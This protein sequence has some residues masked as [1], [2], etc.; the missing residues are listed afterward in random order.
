MTDAV[1]DLIVLA[2]LFGVL[3]RDTICGGTVTVAQCVALQTLTRG[4]WDNAALAGAL[5]VTAGAATRLVDGLEKK[6][7]CSRSR[8][9]E[10]RRRL[11]IE[12]TPEG[13]AEAKRLRDA[14]A[15]AVG[16]ILGAVPRGK[17]TQ[18]RESLHLLRVAAE[19]TRDRITCC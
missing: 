1:E 15:D 16:L 3:E 6:G 4:E 17:R 14:T 13:R 7:W 19:A 8:A 12:L 11:V 9:A 10:D 5:G 2:R 18:V